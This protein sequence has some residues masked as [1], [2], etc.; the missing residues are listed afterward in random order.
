MAK[1]LSGYIT[2]PNGTPIEG[3]V[4]TFISDTFSISGVA[5]TS[6][7]SFITDENGYYY[8]EI[9]YG[10]YL[11]YYQH[12]NA[13]LDNYIFSCT[14]SPTSSESSVQEYYATY[15][16]NSDTPSIWGTITNPTQV[17]CEE[18]TVPF[19]VATEGKLGAV[20]ITWEVTDYLCYD[21]TE[22][23]WSDTNDEST[24]V[25]LITTT[26]SLYT[27]TIGTLSTR[28]Y[29]LRTVRD[30]G[31]PSDFHSVLGTAGTPSASVDYLLNSLTGQIT[32]SQLSANLNNSLSSTQVSSE[33]PTTR[34][35]GSSL[36]TGD[37][38][39]D[40]SNNTY[41]WSTIDNQWH[42]VLDSS[43]YT[44]V[45]DLSSNISLLSG[46]IKGFFQ[47]DAPTAGQMSYGDIWIDTDK[48]DPLD[49][50]CIYRYQDINGSYTGI[51]DWYSTPEV[52]NSSIGL[53]YLTS[54]INNNN[55]EN[56]I[57][58]IASDIATLTTTVDGNTSTIS[59]QQT[60]INGLEAQYVIKLDVN[61]NIAGIGLANTPVDGGG[62]E[63]IAIIQADKFAVTYPVM[64]WSDGLAI[65][66][67]D[68]VSPTVYTGYLYKANN[69]G[70]TGSAEPTWP[71]VLDDTVLDNDVTWKAIY[72]REST[73]FVIGNVDGEST[74]GIN[75]SLVVDDSILARHIATNTINADHINV[76]NL[77]TIKADLGTI[78]AGLMQS[79]DGTFKIDLTGK[80]IVIAGPNGQS[81]DDYISIEQG[82]ITSYTW[83]GSEHVT[84]KALRGIEA[85]DAP[86][87]ST[88]ALTKYYSTQPEVIVTPRILSVYD[89]AYPGQSQALDI[90]AENVTGSGSNW[91]FDV[92]A[93]LI[94]A[95]NS[96]NDTI[97]WNGTKSSSNVI[98][99]TTPVATTNNNTTNI[100]VNCSVKSVRS[101]G[102]TSNYYERRVT[103]RIYYKATSSGTYI[104]GA[105]VTK[106]LL[107]SLDYTTINV[108][109]SGLLANAYDYYIQ[110][111]FADTGDTFVSGATEYDYTQHNI[112]VE[113]ETYQKAPNIL[114]TQDNHY[115]KWEVIDESVD[116]GPTLTAYSLPAGHEYYGDIS[117]KYRYSYY[118]N[119]WSDSIYIS[120]SSATVLGS[121]RFQ[122]GEFPYEIDIEKADV[123]SYG[124]TVSL[125]YTEGDSGLTNW[126][127]TVTETSSSAYDD[128]YFA[129]FFDVRAR[130]FLDTHA[131]Y[132]SYTVA[133][134]KN[135]EA[136][137]D[138]KVEC[139]AE[140]TTRTP[141]AVSTT[142]A[143]DLDVVSA[144]YTLSAGEALAE[145]SVNWLA[146]GADD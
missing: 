46:V 122:A 15:L 143:N 113:T 66:A 73:P 24:K 129:D 96:V 86:N 45:S 135:V 42:L 55:L 48:S 52:Q 125:S 142:P 105:S 87:G 20:L 23:W 13:D 38:W 119:I 6:K 47:N 97:N 144:V 81:A 61:G 32:D 40:D 3:A 136:Y 27:D 102:T 146:I 140:F 130:A 145:G 121:V 4:F 99:S 134:T 93:Q 29:W 90:R 77:S 124:G 107:A 60:S 133:A 1:I 132:T 75:G 114:G 49:Q 62:Q 85:G 139:W 54:Y 21:R 78:T 88:V 110:A 108:T 79:T 104:A 12:P 65:T 14:I 138:V 84:A 56:S 106:D 111:T 51:M 50:T 74:I 17:T 115:R 53:L 9:E 64:P 31:T 63:S 33:A 25:L 100:S 123:D 18:P 28:Y 44:D 126:S 2:T 67:N 59:T 95:G 94:L 41:T 5:K 57:G 112:S 101:T 34:P 128:S 68:I 89:A 16:A 7:S 72:I 39:I 103:L 35:N 26:A 70:T 58:V 127:S 11:V 80:Q 37:T 92:V 30:D 19:N 98:T 71:T 120:A 116:L 76:T 131:S 69:T 82:A 10:N 117:Y 91:T 8:F 137:F 36:I 141:T 109:Q 43:V 22:I 83:T 118:V